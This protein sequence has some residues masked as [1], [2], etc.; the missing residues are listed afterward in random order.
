MLDIRRELKM[1]SKRFG[2]NLRDLSTYGEDFTKDKN[3]NDQTINMSS[4]NVFG[5]L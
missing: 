2:D 3:R 1:S 5:L 4:F